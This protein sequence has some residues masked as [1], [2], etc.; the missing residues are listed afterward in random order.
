M[1]G[2]ALQIQLDKVQVKSEKQKLQIRNATRNLTRV[3]EFLGDLQG[4]KSAK[5]IDQSKLNKVIT[6]LRDAVNMLN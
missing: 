4:K 3:D 2:H 5:D 1:N 6:E